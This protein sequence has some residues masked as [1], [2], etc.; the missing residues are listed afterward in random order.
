MACM[1]EGVIFVVIL[2]PGVLITITLGDVLGFQ[3]WNC[4]FHGVRTSDNH[5]KV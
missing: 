2:L 5:G 4:S 3:P 1:E